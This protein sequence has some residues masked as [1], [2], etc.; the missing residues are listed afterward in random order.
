MVLHGRVDPDTVT[1]RRDRHADWSRN[2]AGRS[3]RDVKPG[4]ARDLLLGVLA[5]CPLV[6][7]AGL[8]SAIVA[9]GSGA[10]VVQII[11]FVGGLVLLGGFMIWAA[12]SPRV[13]RGRKKFWQYA[14]L[15][16]SLV[17]MPIFWYLYVWR[18]TRDI[19]PD[20]DA[21]LRAILDQHLREHRK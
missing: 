13:P 4:R 19:D 8:P 6:F 16:G 20:P 7:S 11:G 18:T 14:L 9:E 12:V 15:F 17:T 2:V 1:D 10:M 5:L 3:R 21:R